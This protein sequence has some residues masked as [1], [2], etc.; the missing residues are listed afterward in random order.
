[1]HTTTVALGSYRKIGLDEIKPPSAPVEEKVP[2]LPEV[3]SLP[4]VQPAEVKELPIVAPAEPPALPVLPPRAKYNPVE[5]SR[6]YR[7]AHKEQ[8]D[9]KRR[10][11]YERNKDK[12]LA[13]KILFNL[14][15]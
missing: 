1:R 5:Y 6:Q 15:R 3:K 7:E 9:K 8:I 2:L 11:E 12:I 14:N 4:I 10:E 13:A